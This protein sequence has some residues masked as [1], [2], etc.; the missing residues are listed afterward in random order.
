LVRLE[1][2]EWIDPEARQRLWTLGG[3]LLDFD[4]ALLGEDVER[5]FLATVEGQRE[6][7][8]PRDVGG[9]LDPQLAD[10]VAVDVH[11]EDGAGVLFGLVGA[12]GKLDPTRLAPSSRQHLGLDDH[13]AAQ[14]LGSR[15]SLLRRGGETPLRDRD[16]EAAEELLALVLV[17][18]HGRGASLSSVLTHR[19]T[20]RIPLA[21]ALCHPRRVRVT[22]RAVRLLHSRRQA[23]DRRSP[24]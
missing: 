13:L 23:P 10:D 3:D 5:A 12:V 18:I 24:G 6:V 16:P 19:L 17:E 20:L 15:S 11:P 8:L 22:T 14:L 1:P 4:A 7:V 21:C 2:L 9:R